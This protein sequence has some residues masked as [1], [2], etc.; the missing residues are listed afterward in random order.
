MKWN[1]ILSCNLKV[2]KNY[3]RILFPKGGQ[4]IHHV[5]VWYQQ[6]DNYTTL[7]T[8]NYRHN[9]TNV[10]FNSFFK[11]R[12]KIILSLTES[13]LLG[14]VLIFNHSF[15]KWFCKRTAWVW[16]SSLRLLLNVL[17]SSLFWT[18]FYYCFIFM[19]MMIIREL[20]K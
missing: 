8:L 16:H 5:K 10:S 11:E 4:V 20:G 2:H 19:Q 6:A 13:V 1:I 14:K 7:N 12:Q 15:S 3:L 17:Y 9:D 18:L